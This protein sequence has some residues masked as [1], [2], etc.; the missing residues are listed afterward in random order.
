M[1]YTLGK[2]YKLDKVKIDQFKNAYNV[3][4][5]EEYKIIHEQKNCLRQKKRKDSKKLMIYSVRKFVH[6]SKT[7]YIENGEENGC[8]I[9][10]K[11]IKNIR[12]H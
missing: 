8:M 4:A 7:V 10:Y 3:Y 9:S 11:T 12:K 2:R 5:I 6:Y 1:E